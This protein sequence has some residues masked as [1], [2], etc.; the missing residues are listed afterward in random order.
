MYLISDALYNPTRHFCEKILMNYGIEINY[1]HPT[2]SIDK[3]DRLVK[4]NTKLIFLESP[5]TATFDIIDF[6]KNNKN[7]KKK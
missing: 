1:F 4:P 7:C 5:G 2:R 3:F 6:L